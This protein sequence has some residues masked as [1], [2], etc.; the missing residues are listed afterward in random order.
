MLLHLKVVWLLKVSWVS[1]NRL[2]SILGLL[3]RDERWRAVCR[4]DVG[5]IYRSRKQVRIHCRIGAMSCVRGVL[6][7]WRDDKS[8]RVTIRIRR[9]SC[10]H[11]SSYGLITV[12]G[13]STT[14]SCFKRSSN[15][16]THTSRMGLGTC[17]GGATYMYSRLDRGQGGGS[18]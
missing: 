15:N 10:K 16:R 14:S 2:L 5:T 3:V 11:R 12:T 13:N 7:F 17:S 9:S 18:R 8:G 4:E 6:N 1:L